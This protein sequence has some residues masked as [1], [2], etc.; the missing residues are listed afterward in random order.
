ML[1]KQYSNQEKRLDRFS[2]KLNESAWKSWQIV[3]LNFWLKKVI[4][5]KRDQQE[6]EKRK[7]KLINFQFG[8]IK[9][10]NFA[11]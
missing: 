10:L 6:K 4:R 8:Y 1:E 2:L 7:N 9:F 5:G 3:K 11:F